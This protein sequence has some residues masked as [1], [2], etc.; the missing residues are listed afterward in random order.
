MNHVIA[1]GASVARDGGA[2]F[3][4]EH[5]VSVIADAC[6]YRRARGADRGEGG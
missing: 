4:R 5:A 3:D 1:S 2:P 6:A